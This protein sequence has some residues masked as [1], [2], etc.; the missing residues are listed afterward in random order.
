M[1]E[2]STTNTCPSK[3][4]S[5][6]KMYVSEMIKGK[7]VCNSSEMKSVLQAHVEEKS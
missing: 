7:H 3:M 6:S 2:K 1:Y 4:K 5:K